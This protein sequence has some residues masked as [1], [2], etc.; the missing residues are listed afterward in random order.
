MR[1]WGG[2]D[3]P[4]RRLVTVERRSGV[5]GGWEDILG[6]TWQRLGFDFR[7]LFGRRRW[8]GLGEKETMDISS[9]LEF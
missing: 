7:G 6:L 9:F 4:Q 2:R 5:G 1:S 8:W 3:L